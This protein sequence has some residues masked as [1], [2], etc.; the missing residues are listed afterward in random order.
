MVQ[1]AG[2]TQQFSFEDMNSVQAKA[3]YCI[4]AVIT[5]HS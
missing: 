5:V 3:L 2:N 4:T 1:A